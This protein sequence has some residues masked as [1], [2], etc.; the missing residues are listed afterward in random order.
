MQDFPWWNDSQRAL[1]AEAR[2]FTDEI[3]MPLAEKSVFKKAYP[4][5]AVREIAKQGWFGA[6]IPEEY[7]GHQKEWG[8]TGASILCEEVG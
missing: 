5:E 4:W 8:V 7:G 6:T 3:L 2:Q 1:M